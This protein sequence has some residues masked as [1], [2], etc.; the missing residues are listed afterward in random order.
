MII[1]W[2]FTPQGYPVDQLRTLKAT[3][4]DITC[5]AIIAYSFFT[6]LRQ[7]YRNKYLGMFVGWIFLSFIFN[8][9]SDFT[10]KAGFRVWNIEPMIHSILAIWTVYILLSV[11]EKEHYL[12]LAKWI[13]FSSLL[14]AS[15]GFM[16]FIGFD[17]V[18][19]KAVY[20][21]AVNKIVAL[22]GNYSL[23]SN[24]LALTCPLF[25]MFN[26]RN[27][28]Y[29]Y[30]F[31][32]LCLI[33]NKSHLAPAAAIIGSVVF[34]LLK[35]REKKYFKWAI[36]CVLLT[37]FLGIGLLAKHSLKT[38]GNIMGR[39]F[40][41]WSLA[42]EKIKENPLFG[43]GLGVY[44]SFEFEDQKTKLIETHNDYIERTCELGFVGLF[45]MLLV[46][47]NSFL[48]F[49]YKN[50]PVGFGYLGMFV[51]FLILMGGFFPFEIAPIA[52]LGMLAFCAV[53]KL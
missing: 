34:I 30:T 13:C 37:S 36:V 8:F 38:K 39:R 9:Y 11:L 4:F 29:G 12:I 47:V 28:Y 44:K 49:N 5:L 51:V 17:P 3:F 31:V 23:L 1:P 53:E 21:Q 10:L 6:G 52:Q 27:Y 26:K 20:F 50:N 7:Q 43:Q 14:V 18:G 42:K 35:I 22:F 15:F 48:K 40:Y 32:M 24:Y 46:I 16:Q 33:L 2:L 41:N 25:L 19:K 45:F